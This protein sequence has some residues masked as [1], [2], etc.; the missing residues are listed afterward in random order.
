MTFLQKEFDIVVI[1]AGPSGSVAASLLNKKGY[2]VLVLEKEQFPRFSIGES[3]LPQCMTYLEQAG[4]LEAVEKAGFQLKNGAAF[5]RG[6]QYEYYDF[7]EKFTEGWGTTFQVQRDRFDKILAD[8]AEKQGVTIRYRQTVKEYSDNEDGATLTV[9]DEQGKEYQVNARFVLDASGFGR[10]L[11]R[12]LNLEKS[13]T[14]SERGALFTHIKDNITDSR[15]DREKILITV[16]PEHHEIWYWLIP[17]SNGRAS[18]GVVVPT[19]FIDKM[20]GNAESQLKELVS[21]GGML[22]EILQS[23]EYDTDV[24]MIGG[25]SSDVSSLHGDNFALLGNAGE[26]LDPVFSSGVTIALTSASLASEV[27]DRQLAGKEPD[28]QR[29][30]VVPMKTGVNAFREFVEGWYDERFQ[31]VVFSKIKNEKITRMISSILAGYAWDTNN[32]YVKE[33]TRLSALAELCRNA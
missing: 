6:G 2:T 31:D 5:T 3:L 27:V 17:F 29:E 18:L 12:L 11:P 25:Y 21:Q 20:A 32:P 10:V 26:F 7:R 13:S 28:W 4:M 30:F 14:L 15:Y 33:P 23:A 22:A 9:D 19:H 1:G 24:R 16:H 8:E